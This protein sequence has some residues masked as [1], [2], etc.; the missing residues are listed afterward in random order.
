MQTAKRFFPNI[1]SAFS[2]VAMVALWLALAPTQAGGLA[3]YIIV[4]GN[5]M[6]PSFHIGDLVI[7][8]EETSYRVG[9]AVVYRNM[10]LENF[11]FH[12]IISE[13]MG[14]F[15]LQGDNNNWV[16]NYQPSQE[17]ILGKLWLHIPRG[18]LAIQ[19]IRSPFVMALVAAGIGAIL[20]SSLFRKRT[21]GNQ[22]MNNKSVRKRS[23]EWFAS[24]KQ[25]SGSWLAQ[26]SGPEPQKPSG[27]DQGSI[28]EASLFALGLILLSSLIIG[29]ISFSRPTSRIVQD[30]VQYQHLGIFSYLAPAPQGVYDSNAIKSGDPIF[31]R[32]TCAVDVNLQYTLIAPDPQNISGTYQLT[33]VIREQISGWQRSVPIQEAASFSGTTF[34]TTAKLD[35][36]KM[37]ALT[38]SMEQET[39]FHPGSYILSVRPN[40]KLSGELSGRTL[41]GRFDAGPNF[42]YDRVHFYLIQSEDV[43]NPLTITEI[44]TIQG[45]RREVN[46]VAFLGTEVAVPVLR[47]LAVLGLLISLAG[48]MLFGVKLQT[49]SKTNQ[50]QFFRV[51]HDSLIVDVHNVET[52]GANCIEVLSIDALAKLAE[53]FNAMILH[54]EQDGSHAYFVQTGGTTYRFVLY[55]KAT[56]LVI[57]ANE[58]THQEVES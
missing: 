49:L 35:L 44:A 36:C 4:I 28:W 6:E 5:S 41:E 23:R 32:L 52:F 22:H 1:S 13:D 39:E 7:A 18:G 57:S 51:R 15:S 43:A 29:I 21:R 16:D 31:P 38:Q 26:V 55:A 24:V 54:L 47:W 14:H 27:S 8:H 12:R 10:E 11:V 56:E 58:N 37:E 33:A 20:A 3:S 2:I 40:I 46:T 50:S 19:K 17:E 9:D 45:E 42:V 34:G 53:R 48:F 25:K 30:E